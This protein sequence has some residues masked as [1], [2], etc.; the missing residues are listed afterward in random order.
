MRR[1][2]GTH[3]LVLVVPRDLGPEPDEAVLEVLVDPEVGDVRAGVAVP[4]GVLA[5]RRGVQVEDGVDAV[6]GAEV[7]HAVEVLEARGFE[8]A[9]VHVI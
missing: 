6:L 2:R 3:L 9:G 7:D 1:G 5:A 4:V 8:D